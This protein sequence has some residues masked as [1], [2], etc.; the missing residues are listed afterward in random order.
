M[1]K[2]VKYKVRNWYWIEYKD[3]NKKYSYTGPAKLKTSMYIYDKN[4]PHASGYFLLP[5]GQTANFFDCDIV[6]ELDEKWVED[7]YPSYDF[8]LEFWKKNRYNNE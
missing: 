3:K 1:T 2:K 6:K 4:K 7:N 8:L 5:S